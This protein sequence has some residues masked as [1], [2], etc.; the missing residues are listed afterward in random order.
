MISALVVAD[1]DGFKNWARRRADAQP[2]TPPPMMA[3]FVVGIDMA[4][5]VGC[6]GAAIA[7]TSSSANNADAMI[8]GICIVLL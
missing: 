4:V 7:S 8:A 1:D 5:V 6:E 2:D 3:I